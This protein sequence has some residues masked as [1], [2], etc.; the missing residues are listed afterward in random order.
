MRK[1]L[2][3]LICMLFP[4]STKAEV[5]NVDGIYYDINME[6][7][8]AAVS[9]KPGFWRC[10]SGNIIIPEKITYNGMEYVVDA[11]GKYAFKMCDDLNSCVLPNSITRI[12]LDGFYGCK[13][14]QSIK[15]PNSV[16]RIGNHAFADCDNLSQVDLPDNI[17]QIDYRAFGNT[18]W[19][20]SI[21][22]NSDEGVVYAN[23]IAFSYKGDSPIS[24]TIKDG[25]LAIAGGAFIAS[26][27]LYS[28]SIP[29]SLKVIG[30][31]AFQNC[32][33]LASIDIPS[34]V[35]LIGQSAFNGCKNLSSVV[36]H[37]GLSKIGNSSFGDCNKISSIYIPQSLKII[38]YGAFG[39]CK[40]LT[41]VH[42][43][44]LSA[45]CKIIFN[46][47]PLE[48]AH[49]LYLK[50][51]LITNLVIP[52]GITTINNTFNG[53]QDLKTVSLND[54]LTCIGNNSFQGCTNLEEVNIN[55]GCTSIGNDAFCQ[56]ENLKTIEVPNTV[57]SIGA[58]AF[59]GCKNISYVSIP[60]K[61]K[62]IESNTFQG[63]SSLKTI[64]IPSS[65]EIIYQEAFD[66]C[67]SLSYINVLANE[68]PFI[69]DNSFSK[70]DA[71]VKVPTGKVNIYRTAQGWNNFININDSYRYKL[72]Y[73]VD[74]AVYKETNVDYYTPI[75]PEPAPVKEG[76]M[77]SG[78]S[79]IP[80][81]MPAHDVT[82]TGSF[83][84]NRYKLSY[85][86][87]GTVYKEKEIDFGAQITPEDSP[88]KEG[89]TFSGW[90]EIPATMPAH[91]VIVTGT[92]TVNKYQLTYILDG[93]EYKTMDVEYG[94]A[95]TPEA[96]PEKEGYVFSG[97]HGLPK[98]MP[99]HVVIV[100][101]A[102][103]KAK[104]MLTY[105]LNDEIYKS[106]EVEYESVITPEPAVEREGHTFSGWSEIPATMPAHDVTVTG[107]LT[108]NKY[109]LTYIVD[110]MEYKT[111][112]VEYGTP[113]IP[114]PEPEKEG[115]SFSGW[116]E[117]P[118][119][120]PA[121]IVI[122]TGTFTSGI[123]TLEQLPQGSYRIY[124]PDGKLLDKPRKGLNI[125]VMADGTVKKLV[126]KEKE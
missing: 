103:S 108:V 126:V 25:T 23:K 88:V 86:V 32:F 24:I 13:K 42:I 66:K 98:T 97:W 9:N 114:E 12:D 106:Q 69:Y 10:Y 43:S 14:L 85:V 11:I 117:I 37:E 31:M 46:S 56:C 15:I 54:D 26:F 40:G 38:D 39:G 18:A 47:N 62:R 49:H 48:Y 77:F 72:T 111:Y 118:A 123:V 35:E 55:V 89:Y 67:Y 76:Y 61:I 45:W 8:T 60:G 1:L 122:V 53:C 94:T 101:G 105:M 17:I 22:N 107:K 41:S 81:I 52:S 91:D 5:V 33:S 36:L 30:E 119:T 125:V 59:K 34:S 70:Y 28:V 90:S 120:M 68:P 100:T 99:A 124:N 93:E 16:E 50:G 58:R 57:S 79:E 63:C 109:I 21:Y 7:G 87:D 6:K 3:V 78:W 80:E 74:G 44:D 51:S 65:V 116:S 2:W 121:H 104:Y 75:V 112:E 115:C 110:G 96:E 73:I 71:L 95:I 4:F 29:N 20:D 19:Y 113:I 92:F 27:D 84:V 64:S 82:V 102:F 83:T